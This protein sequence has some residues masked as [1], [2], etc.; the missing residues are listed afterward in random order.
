MKPMQLAHLICGLA[1]LLLQLR[2]AG[3]SARQLSDGTLPS[4]TVQGK[5]LPRG[6]QRAS[7]PAQRPFMLGPLPAAPAGT[8]LLR[9]VDWAD[10]RAAT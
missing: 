2:A 8:V 4:D 6:K 10:G 1:A 5:K 9:F 7:P 3:A